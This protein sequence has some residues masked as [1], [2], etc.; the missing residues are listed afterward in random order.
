LDPL[1]RIIGP[2]DELR[3][4][5]P[6]TFG[7]DDAWVGY[8]LVDDVIDLKPERRELITGSGAE[9]AHKGLEVDFSREAFTPGTELFNRV[10]D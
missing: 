9:L 2:A 8:L 4:D 3:H 7:S 6:A 10:V 1:Q 5:E